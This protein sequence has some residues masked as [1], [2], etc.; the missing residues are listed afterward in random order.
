[1]LESEIRPL[2]QAPDGWV[3]TPEQEQLRNC[4]AG[5]LQ[6][7]ED[8]DTV[9]I[10]YDLI[11]MMRDQL[12]GRAADVRRVAAKRARKNMTPAALALA[13]GQTRQTISRLLTE[14]RDVFEGTVEEEVVAE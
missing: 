8:V 13:S 7:H 3:D 14:A 10:C 9:R 6:G 12:M 4:L 2:L 11:T 5:V 1:M